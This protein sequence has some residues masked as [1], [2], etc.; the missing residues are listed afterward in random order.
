MVLG[1]HAYSRY[2]NIVPY[3][4]QYMDIPIFKNGWLGVQ[5]FFLISGF[6]IFMSLDRCQS[7]KQFLYKRWTRLFPAMLIATVLIFIT[8]SFF[9]E[10]PAGPPELV[11]LI[12][13]LTFIEPSWWGKLLGMNVKTHYL[14]PGMPGYLYPIIPIVILTGTSYIIVKYGEPYLKSTIVFI[15]DSK[16]NKKIQRT[17]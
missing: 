6:V 9:Y 15:F 2:P 5:L 1:F 7:S 12:P 3:G 10:R 4:N 11:N 17:S 14:L 13:G 16:S 8:S